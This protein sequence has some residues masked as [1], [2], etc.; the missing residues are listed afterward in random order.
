MRRKHANINCGASELARDPLRAN[1]FQ[2]EVLTAITHLRNEHPSTKSVAPAD[3]TPAGRPILALALEI[4]YLTINS[5]AHS[6]RLARPNGCIH[7]A[8]PAATGKEAGPVSS[9][10]SNPDD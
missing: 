8:S 7:N 4:L 10:A 3:V 2:R 9:G 5:L 6:C 1:R